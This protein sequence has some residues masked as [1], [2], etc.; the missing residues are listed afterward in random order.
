VRIG[1]PPLVTVTTPFDAREQAEER[2][3]VLAG[4]THVR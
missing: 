3:V 1:I 2:S 4:S